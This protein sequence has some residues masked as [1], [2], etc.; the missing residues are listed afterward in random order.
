LV[1]AAPDSSWAPY[2]AAMFGTPYQDLKKEYYDEETT[3]EGNST[4]AFIELAT[5]FVK[6]GQQSWLDVTG[7]QLHMGML[8]RPPLVPTI[9]LVQAPVFDLALFW[10]LRVASDTSHPIWILPI[11]VE[12]ANDPAVLDKLKDWLLAFHACGFQF[13]F[14]E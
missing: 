10:N 14:C 4:V 3:F 7:H 5:E 6:R 9:V 13:N 1:C 8:D 12:D 11:P 2:C